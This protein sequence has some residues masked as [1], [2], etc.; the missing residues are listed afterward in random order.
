MSPP[1]RLGFT[2]IELLVVIAIIAVLI[3]I[4]LPAIQKVRE[5]A[6]RSACSN[7]LHQ[8]GVALQGYH[9]A[10]GGFPPGRIVR[11][12]GATQNWAALVLP[13]IEETALY[14]R[15]NFNAD[16]TA[17]A[18]DSGV[19]QTPIKLFVCPSAPAGRVG[20]NNRGILDYPAINQVHRPNPFALNGLP[21]SDPTYVGVL[22]NNV[23]RPIVTI[24][25]GTTHTLLL[26][27]DAGRNQSWEMG[28]LKGSLSES[29]AWANPG[30]AIVVSGFNPATGTIPGPVAVNGCNSQNVYA[31][32]PGQAGGLFADGS[33][34]FLKSSTSVD[35]LIALTT[36]K[37]REVIPEDS[38]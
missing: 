6:S 37:G 15:Y 33:V 11:P 36:R 18:N 34:R 9:D 32:H 5:A 28:Q 2:L 19:N 31:F 10:Y 24:L 25:D 13:F 22:G 4:L 14:Q 3:G 29:G 17:A 8:L 16:W 1:R 38:F 12:N 20:A 7:N 21:P 27:E 23:S 35:V 26:A 30:G